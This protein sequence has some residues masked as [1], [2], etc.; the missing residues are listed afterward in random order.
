MSTTE[1]APARYRIAE[2]AR[3]SGFTPTT[4]RYYEKAGVL[5]PPARTDAGYRTYDDRDLERL[6]L[7]AR[8]KELGC[9]LDE[10]GELV[11]AWD[12][13]ACGPVKHRLRAL[14]HAKITAVQDHLAEQAAFAAQLQATAAALADRPLDGPCDDSCGCTTAPRDAPSSTDGCGAGCACG[15]APA[16]PAPVEL[17]TT[18]DGTPAPPI[19]CSLPGDDM[20]G[21]V[22][23]WRSVLAGVTRRQPRPDGVRLELGSGAPLAAIAQ[24]A[25][26]EH[27]CCPFFGFAL[28]IDRRGTALEV[29]APAGGQA[30]LAA[31]FGVA[32]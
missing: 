32:A 1:T 17:A 24:L 16:G 8:A 18:A 21:R 11:E 6:R 7:I 13:D 10:I 3:L 30:L 23:E 12:D 28:T 4:L 19:A 22:A 20:E 2:I 26:A 25:E 14:V 5:D 29:T 27:A 15:A 9:S 31:V